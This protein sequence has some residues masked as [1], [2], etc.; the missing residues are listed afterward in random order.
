MKRVQSMEQSYR[1]QRQHDKE[2]M[3]ESTTALKDI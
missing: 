3:R 1:E 2:M